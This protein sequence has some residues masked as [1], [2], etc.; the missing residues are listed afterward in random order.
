[1][2]SATALTRL[3]VSATA[4]SL[5]VLL[6][7]FSGCT[8]VATSTSRAISGTDSLDR[9]PDL[10]VEPALVPISDFPTKAQRNAYIEAL[11]THSDVLCAAYK[12]KIITLS[13]DQRLS[14]DI[15][16]TALS[17]AAALVGTLSAANI[18]AG[19][20]TTVAAIG[21]TFSTDTFN[22]Q[23]GEIL[24][25]AIQTARDNQANQI[26]INLKQNVDDYSQARAVRDVFAY[27]HMCGLETAFASI[28]SSL[29]TAS[30]DAGATPQAAQGQQANTG[31]VA[32]PPAPPSPVPAPGT[33]GSL[34]KSNQPV[35][36]TPPVVPAD[37]MGHAQNKFE[38]FAKT[39]GVKMQ[40]AL[41]VAP[42]GDLG[43]FGSPTR[44]A[45]AQFRAGFAGQPLPTTPPTADD[46]TIRNSAERT[47]LT[48]EAPRV[49]VDCSTP[50]PAFQ[51][52]KILGGHQ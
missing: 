37:Q 9:A 20:G 1:M 52:G 12:D 45:I 15:V 10:S 35:T 51:L 36:P 19:A 34:G 29:K 28:R 50:N 17:G 32:T 48:L 33:P 49:A 7:S 47:R 46:Q 11:M 24:A 39:R 6:L 13:R 41:C 21:G 27:H 14:T 23:A 18:L 3:R 40:R 2:G 31:L 42:D 8:Q 5:F 22:Q 44:L 30:P 4:A 16:H 26:E 25:S 43:T 38:Q